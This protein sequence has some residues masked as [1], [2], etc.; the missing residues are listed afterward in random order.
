VINLN[1][2]TWRNRSRQRK[3]IRL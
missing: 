3:Q 2:A 1:Q